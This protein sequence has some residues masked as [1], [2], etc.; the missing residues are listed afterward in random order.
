MGARPS[1]R[2]SLGRR[3]R[4]VARRGGATLGTSFLAPKTTTRSPLA[5]IGT[6]ARVALQFT[7]PRRS[8]KW[9]L[10]AQRCRVHFF[11]RT[12]CD[13]TTRLNEYQLGRSLDDGL[14]RGVASLQRLKDCSERTE[15]APGPAYVGRSCPAGRARHRIRS[16]RKSVGV[17]R[18]GC[19]SSSRVAAPGAATPCG[20]RLEDL[21]TR[22]R[23]AGGEGIR[24]VLRT[25]VSYRSERGRVRIAS[26]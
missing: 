22:L 16:R 3:V 25:P 4:R 10:A 24:R 1:R 5:E 21:P 8:A 20:D 18:P 26:A 15:S 7:V 11:E 13:C 2:R 6:S 19:L 9:P 12:L 23:L 14:R 17:E